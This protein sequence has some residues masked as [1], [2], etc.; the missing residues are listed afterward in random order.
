V[1]R[2]AAAAGMGQRRQGQRGVVVGHGI[3]GCAVDCAVNRRP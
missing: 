1:Q 3:Q 2:A